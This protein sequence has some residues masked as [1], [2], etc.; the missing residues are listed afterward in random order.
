MCSACLEL[1]LVLA[2]NRDGGFCLIELELQA[3]TVSLG[4][5]KMPRFTSW[6]KRFTTSVV[7]LLIGR[8]SRLGLMCRRHC[9]T[10][11]AFFSVF[12]KFR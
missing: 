3:E 8:L 5:R 9:R 4:E 6:V 11:F 10:M 12:K 2:G 1:V 7:L